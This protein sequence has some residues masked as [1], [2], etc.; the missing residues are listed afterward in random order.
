M[1]PSRTP[2]GSLACIVSGRINKDSHPMRRPVPRQYLRSAEVQIVLNSKCA[3]DRCPS[4]S[5]LC[6]Q[7]LSAVMGGDSGWTTQ[8]PRSRFHHVRRGVAAVDD[9]HVSKRR[10]KPRG[11]ICAINAPSSRKTQVRAIDCT[12][13]LCHLLRFHLQRCLGRGWTWA[14]ALMGEQHSFSSQFAGMYTPT[15]TTRSRCTPP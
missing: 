7:V 5:A 1:V 8:V 2:A 9:P 10:D 4:R 6:S 15:P 14:H 11:Y 12:S 13:L 3:H